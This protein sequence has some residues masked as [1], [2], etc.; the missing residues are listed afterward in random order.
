MAYRPQA[1]RDRRRAGL[2]LDQTLANVALLAAPG[3]RE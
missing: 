3:W 1:I 2:R